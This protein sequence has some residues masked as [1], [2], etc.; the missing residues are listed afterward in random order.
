MINLSKS[1]ASKKGV[2]KS[3]LNDE[4]AGKGIYDKLEEIDNIITPK[5]PPE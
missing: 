5:P 2:F 4:P 1:V 3:I